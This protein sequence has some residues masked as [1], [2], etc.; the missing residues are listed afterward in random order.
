M[1]QREVP[2]VLSVHDFLKQPTEEI[3][4][5]LENKV[6]VV[7]GAGSGIG[8]EIARLFV[9]EGAKVVIADHN[10][11]GADEVAKSSAPGAPS[12]LRSTLPT[13]HRSRPALPGPS[14]CSARSTSW[15]PM[16][17]FSR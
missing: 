14:P 7:T 6:A 12:A 5:R 4:M 11:E 17:A 3:T 2:Q 15:F 13:R 9:R 10:Q 8:K 16:P 1:K